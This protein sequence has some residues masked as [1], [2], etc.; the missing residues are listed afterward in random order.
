MIFTNSNSYISH[1]VY[2]IVKIKRDVLMTSP[3]VVVHIW[4]CL[5]RDSPKY[6]NLIMNLIFNLIMNLIFNLCMNLIFNLIMNLVLNL[7]VT[8]TLPVS[9]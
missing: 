6:G 2:I 8:L 3:L 9:G 7:V 4:S 1:I 5:L